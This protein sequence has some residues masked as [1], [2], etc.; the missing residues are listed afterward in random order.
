MKA[1]ATV[2]AAHIAIGCAAAHAIPSATPPEKR[3]PGWVEI[4]RTQATTAFLDTARLERRSDGTVDAWFRLVYTQPISPDFYPPVDYDAAESRQ[5][6]DCA[7]ERTRGLEMRMQPVGGKPT[8]SKVP[9]RDWQPIATH[10]LGSDL[11]R[12]L[13]R[14]IDGLRPPAR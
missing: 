2:L 3:A 1:Y 9:D 6:V 7:R 14:S 4:A 12:I 13:C 10:R 8:P 5:Q 11:F